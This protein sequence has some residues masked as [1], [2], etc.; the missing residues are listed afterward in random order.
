M[1][2]IGNILRTEREKKG[3]SIKDIENSTSIRSLYIN[4]IEENDFK[5]IPGE[6]Y[7]KGFIR[8]YASCL[9]LNPQEI[10]DVYR[11][12]QAES[13]GSLDPN[14]FPVSE[15]VT[16][17]AIR[18]EETTASSQKSSIGKWLTIGVVTAGLVGGAI[19]WFT[20]TMQPAPPQMKEQV[21]NSPAPTPPAQPSPPTAATQPAPATKPISVTAKFTEDCWILVNADGKDIH[22]GMQKSGDS[23][24]WEAQNVL[25]I[26]VGNAGGVDITYNGQPQGKLGTKG[27]VTQK[28]FLINTKKP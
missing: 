9:G 12:M 11:K 8:N 4:A 18:G 5:V 16:N 17:E 22:E 10:M 2:T 21:Q 13:E 14:G 26:K 15:T 24:T 23:F 6:V 25:T 1:E 27:E 7:V 3:L 20:S 28:T 19:W